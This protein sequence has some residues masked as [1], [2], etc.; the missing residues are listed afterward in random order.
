MRHLQ[1]SLLLF[2]VAF[3]TGCP[4]KPSTGFPD[5]DFSNK[6]TFVSNVNR[7]LKDAHDQYDDADEEKDKQRIRNDAIEMALAV[8]DDNY[9]D[10]I[11]HLDARRSKSEFLLDVIELGVGAATGISKGERPNQILGIA[12]TAFRGGRRSSELSF[13]KQQ[14]TPILISKMDDS[15][16]QVLAGILNRKTRDTDEYSLNAAIRDLVA[17]YN[18]GTLIRAFT[19]LGKDAAVSAKASEGVVRKLRGDVEITDI[20]TIE[21]EK[22]SLGILRLRESL[23]DEKDA[24]QAEADNITVPAQADPPTEANTEQRN[25]ALAQKAAKLKPI[26]DKLEKIWN[27]VKAQDAFASAIAKMKTQDAYQDILAKLDA[28]PPQPVTEED[29]LTLLRGLQAELANNAEASKL[30]LAILRRANQ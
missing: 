10:F 18:A 15:R 5:K 20:P 25:A 17:Y 21:A 11:N 30:F 24:A 23:E 1:I 27:E 9:N 22:V 3:A 4:N 26:R 29:Y 12:I 16:A 2:V 6:K 19:E 8:V 13:Y 14:T 7:F 28:D